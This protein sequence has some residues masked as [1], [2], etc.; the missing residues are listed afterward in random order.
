MNPLQIIFA[1]VSVLL[2]YVIC[3]MFKRAYGNKQTKGC[4][5]GKTGAMKEKFFQSLSNFAST[6]EQF[7]KEQYE[8]LLPHEQKEFSDWVKQ[9]N[10]NLL[11]LR[12][13]VNMLFE[14]VEKK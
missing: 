13:M 6:D 3:S 7:F 10:Y 2:L 5:H 9:S 12:G 8:D 1:L 11:Q 4:L 14:I